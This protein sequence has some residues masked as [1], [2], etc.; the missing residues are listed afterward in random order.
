[1]HVVPT[2]E[3]VRQVTD[4][5]PAKAGG[6]NFAPVAPVEPVSA[7]PATQD[8]VLQF[9]HDQLMQQNMRAP[10]AYLA[11]Q[12]AQMTPGGAEHSTNAAAMIYAAQSETMNGPGKNSADSIVI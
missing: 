10:A 7:I 2:L 5:A 9:R 4:P 8:D 11:Q 12:I 3:I 1:M 6:G